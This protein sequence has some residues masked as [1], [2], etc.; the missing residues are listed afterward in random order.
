[1]KHDDWTMARSW[2]LSGA[3]SS[4]ETDRVGRGGPG[5]GGAGAVGISS[6]S[7][8]E[9]ILVKLWRPCAEVFYF[10]SGRHSS[11]SDILQ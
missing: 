5:V 4:E 1:M 10:S 2:V 3:G 7:S 8:Q 6:V 9:E 11:P